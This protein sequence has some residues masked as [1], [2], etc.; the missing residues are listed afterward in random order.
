[1]SDTPG[2]EL[3]SKEN[4]GG[5]KKENRKKTLPEHYSL[6]TYRH[7]QN[8]SCSQQHG[9]VII[10]WISDQKEFLRLF[11]KY[12]TQSG[13]CT[14]TVNAGLCTQPASLDQEELLTQGHQC[15]NAEAPISSLLTW[16]VIIIY[17]SLLQYRHYFN[18]DTLS[19][20]N[21]Q[22]I[23][24]WWFKLQQKSLT[25]EDSCI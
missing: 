23:F 16:A 21:Y 4:K 10:R 20:I 24:D 1:M 17:F 14:V 2:A 13:A 11:Y 15:H 25:Q 19:N 7:D 6:L 5:K 3:N 12:V 18:W 22:K 8:C 9:F